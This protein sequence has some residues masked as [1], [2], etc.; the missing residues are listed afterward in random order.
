M[1]NCVFCKIVRGEIPCVKVYENEDVLAFE[2][3]NP[4]APVHVIV[5]PKKHLPTLM[6]VDEQSEPVFSALLSAAQKIAKIKGVAEKGFRV[7][8]NC[9]A[10]GGQVV[11]HLHLHILGGRKLVDEMG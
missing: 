6:D 4:T 10:E 8:V 1:S 7:V 3:I 11:F 2:D 5:V 9:N